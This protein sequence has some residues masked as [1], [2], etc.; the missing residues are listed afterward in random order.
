MEAQEVSRANF[1]RRSVYSC[2]RCHACCECRIKRRHGN[3][4][5]VCALLRPQRR[6]ELRVHLV[7]AMPIDRFRQ[8]LQLR[9]EPMVST[10][11]ATADLFPTHN[12][13]NVTLSVSC[14]RY[15][16]NAPFARIEALT[17]VRP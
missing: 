5:V 8:R 16:P 15:S 6:Y 7:A 9:S 14:R 17:A 13:V 2:D 4:S 1:V 11:P 10:L 3:L 12:A